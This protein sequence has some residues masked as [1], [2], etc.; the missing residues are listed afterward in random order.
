MPRFDNFPDFYASLT[1]EQNAHIRNLVDWVSS[2]YPKFDPVIA[3][4]QPMFKVGKT[5]L[6]GFMPAKNHT[7][8]LTVTDT[9]ISELSPELSGYDHGTRSIKIPLGQDIDPE[10]FSKI[11]EIRCREEGIPFEF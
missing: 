10:L 5:Y 3:W 1:P 2:T 7:N 4:N 8:L 11:L 9:A 6:V